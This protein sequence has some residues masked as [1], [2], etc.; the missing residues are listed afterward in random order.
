MAR[1][2]RSH[3]REVNGAKALA[4]DHATETTPL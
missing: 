3:V 1:V 2:A 4:I